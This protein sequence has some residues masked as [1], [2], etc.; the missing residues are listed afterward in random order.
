MVEA[1]KGNAT[2]QFKVGEYHAEGWN[3]GVAMKWFRKAAE[4]GHVESQYRLGNCLTIPG[5]PTDSDSVEAMKWWH[6]AA[7][8]GHIEA[9]ISLG[10]G[11]SMAEV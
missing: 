9:Q 8:Q 1:E 5:V 10:G 2:A 7:D 4:Q 11:T 3:R 6:K